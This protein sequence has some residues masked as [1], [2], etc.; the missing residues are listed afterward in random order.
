MNRFVRMLAV[1][2]FAGF[3]LASS[4]ATATTLAALSHDQMVDA[5]ALIVE[6]TV[7]TVSTWTDDRG[8]TW[9]RASVRVDRSLKGSA[10]VGEVVTVEAPG[11]VGEDGSITYVSLTPRYDEGERV[12]LYLDPLRKG[13]VYGTIGLVRGKFT[14]RQN[15]ADGSDMVVRFTVPVDHPYD[16]RFI[17]H[18]PAAE[19]VSL[20][21]VEAKIQA[22]V[23]TGWDGKPIAGFTVD[24]LRSINK[25]QPGVK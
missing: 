5:S 13:T 8:R 25:L 21:S 14:I 10:D 2:V 6:G 11:G 23:A 12:L 16:A 18:P 9:T 15:P 19:R 17:P 20:V 1:G 7:L 4:P 3:A 22:R 24:H